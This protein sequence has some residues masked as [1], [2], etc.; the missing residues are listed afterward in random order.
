[1]RRWAA[2]AMLVVSV[3]NAAPQDRRVITIDEAEALAVHRH[4]RIAAAGFGAQAAAS[5]IKQASAAFRPLV[6]ASVTTAG[7]DRD[8]A[9]AAGTLQTSGLASRAATGIGLSQLITDFGRT[10]NLTDAARRRADA[11]KSNIAQTRAEVL[12]QVKLAYYSVLASDASLKVARARVQ[13]QDV[14]LRQVRA[15]AESKLKSTLDVSFAE[16]AL[17]EAQM[18]LY[19]AENAATASRAQLASAMGQEDDIDFQVVDMALP[20]RPDDGVQVMIAQAIRNRPDLAAA[21][22]GEDAAQR[23]AAAEKRLRYPAISAIAVLGAVPVHQNNMS[24]QYS[25][26]GLNISIPFLNGGALKAR[27]AEAEFRAQGAGKEAEA[28]RVQIAASVRLA[29]LEVDTAWRRLDVTARLVN[30]TSTALR[31]ASTRYELG[32]SGILELTQAQL[33]QTSAQIAAANAKYDYLSRTAG[34]SY[35]IGDLR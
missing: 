8:T 20:P 15:L 10:S 9:I 13:M 34:L 27:W 25:S 35:A 31:L 1:M 17:S 23:F 3:R 5:A 30:Q 7:A 18:A 2:M 11:Q 32:L 12:L 16:V 19:Q 24:G 4:P 28:L 6:S 33:A 21:R 14:T 29:N 26:A 22:L